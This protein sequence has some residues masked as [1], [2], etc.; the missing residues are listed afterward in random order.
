[1][2][3]EPF[4][5]MSIDPWTAKSREGSGGARGEIT[6]PTSSKQVDARV[7]V[8]MELFENGEDRSVDEG[9]GALDA[10]EVLVPA[11]TAHARHTN[12]RMCM[13][14]E[15]MRASLG[16]VVVIACQCMIDLLLLT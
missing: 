2:V 13:L 7:V 12:R 5:M 9:V 10:A 4:D 11:V 14:R 3:T 15:I 16:N 6:V 1:M 8:V